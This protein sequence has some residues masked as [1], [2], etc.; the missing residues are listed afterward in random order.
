MNG[1]AGPDL[2]GVCEVENRFVL[3][4]LVAALNTP[5]CR[6]ATTRSCTP[7]PT[8]PAASTSPSST[9]PT[10][11]RRLPARSSS[12]S[13]MRR[14]AT[15]EIVQVN[16]QTTAGPDLGGLRQP[17]AVAQRRPVR[18]GRL[19]RHRRRDPRLLPRARPRGARRR[20][21]PCSRWATSTT[22]RSTPRWSSTRSAPASANK[23]VNA[24]TPLFWNLSVAADRRPARR[25][26]LLR[27]RTQPARPVPRQQEHGHAGPRRS[28]P[29]PRRWRSSAS[30]APS[31]PATTRGR[32]RSAAWASPIDEDGYSDHFPIGMQVTEAD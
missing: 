13:S 20:T 8:T 31:A 19:P 14:N 17:L 21:R 26:L 25:H 22:S 18:V 16:F 32:S 12:T 29:R 28:A 10:S 4:L 3:D 24:D 30:P 11:S 15:R 1:G 7:T 9:T 23:V 2:L 6:A 27:Q 5:R